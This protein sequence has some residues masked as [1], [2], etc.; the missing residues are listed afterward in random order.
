MFKTYGA[1][2]VGF[3]QLLYRRDGWID[4]SQYA[5]TADHNIYWNQGVI[6]DCSGSGCVVPDYEFMYN[7]GETV[8]LNKT[9]TG[10]MAKWLYPLPKFYGPSTDYKDNS[11]YL[12]QISLPADIVTDYFIE[13][14]PSYLSNYSSLCLT[15]ASYYMSDYA[16][17]NLLNNS[18]S[19]C[20]VTYSSLLGG[21]AISPALKTAYDKNRTSLLKISSQQ[22]FVTKSEIPI[23]FSLAQNYPNPFNP[24]TLINYSIPTKD[25]ISL[26]VFDALGREVS[27]L[28]S[29]MKEAGNYSVKFDGSKL[30]SG[31]YV[32]KLSSS[33]QQ[34][35]KKLL[36]IK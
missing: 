25:Y 8:V 1:A 23:E 36:L 31:I 14:N 13:T 5:R 19:K 29:E 30:S 16:Y 15:A 35:S 6:N 34:M 3:S 26:K 20:N 22:E 9:K 4:G 7:Y 21:N 27:S 12:G 24:T 10:E 2:H 17:N 18:I 11:I 28:V 33:T 32:Y